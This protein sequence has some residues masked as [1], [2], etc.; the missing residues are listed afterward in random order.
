[1]RART[2][3]FAHVTFRQEANGP[4][5][6]R[7]ARLYDGAMHKIVTGARCGAALLSILVVIGFVRPASADLNGP[8]EN[9]M[10]TMMKGGSY[11]FDMTSVIG[12]STETNSGDVASLSP[13]RMRATM[14]SPQM[15]T[16]EM[17]LLPSAGYMKMGSGAWQKL[18]G[19]SAIG[20]S[21]MDVASMM[22]KDRAQLTVVDL[23]MQLKDGAMLHA[24]RVTDSARKI[25]ETV[26]LDGAGRIARLEAPRLVMRFS[27][28][29]E[30]VNIAAP[31]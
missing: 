9:A 16:M 24:Y 12:G 10:M 1:M 20:F 31:I 3:S 23:G 30:P 21:Q 6:E 15:G 13:L 5:A 27:K 28:Y 22:A 26:Y 19:A 18:P 25:T 17:I 2:L 14:T 29:G 8:L 7:C 4:L 11:H